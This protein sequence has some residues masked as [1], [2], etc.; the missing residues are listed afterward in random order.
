MAQHTKNAIRQAFIALLN[1]RSL[2]KISIKDIAERSSVNRNTFYY[3]YSDIYALVED[4]FQIEIDRFLEKMRDYHSWQEAFRAATEF[5][6]ENKRAVYH[7]FG[8]ENRETLEHYY[9]KVTFA[10]MASYVRGQAEGLPVNESDVQMVTEFYTAALAGL[11]IDWLH[12]GMKTD[13]DAYIDRLGYLLDGNIR[14]S[15]ERSCR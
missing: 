10:A 2:D 8:S 15:L 4:I 3:Y 5:A 1:E 13:T 14:R 11:T 9:H 12:G 6:F 7:L